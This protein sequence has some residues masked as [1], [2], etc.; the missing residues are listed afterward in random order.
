[1]GRRGP[2]P[3]SFPLQSSCLKVHL[4]VGT[5]RIIQHQPDLKNVANET[6]FSFFAVQDSSLSSLTGESNARLEI[7]NFFAPRW[8]NE[9]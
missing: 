2:C 6:I 9:E 5:T 4:Q 3:F 7:L 1:M 8:L